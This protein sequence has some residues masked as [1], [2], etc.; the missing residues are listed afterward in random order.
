M[1]LTKHRRKTLAVMDM[2]PMIDITFQLLIF[3]MTC[4]QISRVNNESKVE[5]P[6]AN[7][8]VTTE[9]P[10]KVTLTINITQDG[11]IK[12][13]GREYSVPEVAIALTDEFDAV[14]REPSRM[15]VVVRAD[16]RGTCRAVNEV[17]TTLNKTGINQVHLMTVSPR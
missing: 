4:S 12:I 16:K 14:G 1:R 3:F 7:P 9:Q 6:E 2:T 8:E 11:E 13:T 10:E 15:H 17:I 5:P